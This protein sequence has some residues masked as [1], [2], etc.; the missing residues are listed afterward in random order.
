MDS[1]KTN[2]LGLGPVK[3][4]YKKQAAIHGPLN[5]SPT[6]ECLIIPKH[7]IA[8]YNFLTKYLANKKTS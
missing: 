4:T 5:K 2:G 6:N 7:T 3:L 1:M 8:F